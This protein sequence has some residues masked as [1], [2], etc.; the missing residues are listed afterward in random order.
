MNVQ[1]TL[2]YNFIFF[3]EDRL[4][5]IVG[6]GIKVFVPTFNFFIYS[7]YLLF[8]FIF[9]PLIYTLI[10]VLS[11]S[12]LFYI[13]RFIRYCLKGYLDFNISFGEPK[14]NP[15]III[16]YSWLTATSSHAYSVEKFKYNALRLGWY[17][18][19]FLCKRS[20]AR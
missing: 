12:K 2:M 14:Q 16:E 3:R 6:H 5:F 11:L 9:F 17:S 20:M 10:H 18:V 7:H 13:S 19:Q 1:C 4:P 15:L 8:F